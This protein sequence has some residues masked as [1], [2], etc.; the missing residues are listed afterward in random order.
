MV[1]NNPHIP[2]SVFYAK[3]TL[4]FSHLAFVILKLL[5]PYFAKGTILKDSRS[6]QID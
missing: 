2:H 6:V 4:L 5:H 3:I 1:Q